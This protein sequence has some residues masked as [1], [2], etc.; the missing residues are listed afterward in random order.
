MDSKIF[1]FG[2]GKQRKG[3]LD[4]KINIRKKQKLKGKSYTNK[5]GKTTFLVYITKQFI[6][7]IQTIW[8]K[9]F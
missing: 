5:I 7:Y 2:K 1:L 6:R 9:V 8:Y 4:E 3:N